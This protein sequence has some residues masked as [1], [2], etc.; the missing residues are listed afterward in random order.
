MKRI[1]I[2][3]LLCCVST[4][5][6]AQGGFNPQN[7]GQQPRRDFSP[8]EY[9]RV[10]QDFVTHEA[11]LTNEEAEKFYPMLKEMMEE[12]HKNSRKSFEVYRSC[13]EGTTESEYGTAVKKLLELEVENRRIEE[14]YY[15]K[16]HTVMSWEKVF[17]VRRALRHWNR[18]ALNRFNPRRGGPPP[19]SNRNWPH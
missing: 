14:T 9:W 6:M 8:E 3:I 16:F 7:W 19:H 2:N 11:H 17:N 15:K 5:A 13:N 1:L 18:E 10:L 4:V 12:Q